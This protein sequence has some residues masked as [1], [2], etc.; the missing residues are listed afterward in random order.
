LNREIQV[1]IWGSNVYFLS[2]E[3]RVTI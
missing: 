1:N 3:T 2:H